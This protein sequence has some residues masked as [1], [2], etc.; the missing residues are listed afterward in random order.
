MIDKLVLQIPF[1]SNWVLG[2]DDVERFRSDP[3]TRSG[4]FHVLPRWIPSR[5]AAKNISFD[6]ASLVTN[7][8]DL[9]CPWE[10][11]P[12]SFSGLALKVYPEGNGAC[13][14]PYLQLKASPAKLVQGHNVYGVDD[15]FLA[16]KNFLFV[17]NSAY[18]AFVIGY[19]DNRDLV[20]MGPMLDFD[21][22]RV[23]EIDITYSL[24]MP[25][26]KRRLAFINYI[27]NLSK[28]QTRP[29]ADAYES[30]AYFGA[31]KSAYKKLKVYLK[32]FEMINEMSGD[33]KLEFPADLLQLASD[34]VRFEAT[35]KR[36]FFESMGVSCFVR[37]LVKWFRD[38]ESRYRACWLR[39]FGDLFAALDGLE[40]KV[41]NDDA[42]FSAL[43]SVHG[44]TRGRVARLF[45]FWQGLCGVGFQ[46]LRRQYPRRTFDRYV[47]D[48]RA[49]G[50]SDAAIQKAADHSATVF[51]LASVFSVD[52]IVEKAP[53]GFRQLDLA[54]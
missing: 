41:M 19:P 12:S 36:R 26:E 46:A 2:P 1:A 5:Q 29:G 6:P 31:K 44:G 35:L 18:P 9:Y 7:A 27:N 40:L 42:V 54:A 16:V 52:R 20:G 33:K 39:A 17:L 4:P 13:K 24:S 50:L 15:L 47:A 3:F 21:S 30:T 34:L 49:A 10:S 8:E 43:Q 14:W 23:S 22:M 28:G 45:G 51:R 25:D 11:L 38:D 32:Y 37:D 53:P 48:L